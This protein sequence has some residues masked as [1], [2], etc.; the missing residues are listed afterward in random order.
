MQHDFAAYRH[1][2]ELLHRFI[3]A[4]GPLMLELQLENNYLQHL[5][6]LHDFGL[7]RPAVVHQS[8]V[9]LLRLKTDSEGR[10]D[11]VS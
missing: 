10:A 4:R 11:V 6:N 3:R 9:A 7:I 1:L 8:F 5:V 2:P